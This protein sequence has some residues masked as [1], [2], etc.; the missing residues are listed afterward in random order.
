MFTAEPQAL[1]TY[2]LP[3]EPTLIA[4][5]ASHVCCVRGAESWFY[6]LA[7]GGAALR[8]QYPAAVDALRLAANRAAALCQGR[9]LLHTVSHSDTIMCIMA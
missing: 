9:A 8:R 3:A 7:G 5:G 2:T 4:L 6:P 1:A